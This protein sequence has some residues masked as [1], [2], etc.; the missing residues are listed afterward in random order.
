MCDLTA[1]LL[2]A[3]IIEAA[4]PSVKRQIDCSFKLTRLP[5]LGLQDKSWCLDWDGSFLVLF[6]S[7]TFSKPFLK[8]ISNNNFECSFSDQVAQP[9]PNGEVGGPGVR[10]QALPGFSRSESNLAN[11]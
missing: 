10:I 4:W 3:Y 5:D 11:R 2:C 8:M 9:E 1:V 7:L 6:S